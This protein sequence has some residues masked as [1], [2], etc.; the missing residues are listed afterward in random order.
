MFKNYELT[1]L[2]R[3]DV[4]PED[5]ESLIVSLKDIFLEYRGSK[6]LYGEY[7]G[8]RTLE[9]K[10]KKQESAHFYLLQ[11]HSSKEVN[12][13]LEEQLAIKDIVI[14]Y[15]LVNMDEEPA[16]ISP[17]AKDLKTDHDAGIICDEKYQNVVS[18][19]V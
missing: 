6:F 2:F 14:R 3:S 19:V 9:Y 11:M 13:M 17:N 7:W 15:L 4:T 1:L 10:I 16:I 18:L 8:L 5:I 12:D